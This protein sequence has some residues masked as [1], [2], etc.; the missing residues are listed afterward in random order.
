MTFANPE[1]FLFLLLL[2]VALRFK[3]AG[4]RFWRRGSKAGGAAPW[5]FANFIAASRAKSGIRAKLTWLPTMLFALGFAAVVVAGARPQTEDWE[6]LMAQGLDV[7][8]CLDMSSSMNAVDITDSE[9]NEMILRGEIPKN[10]FE[11]AR[12]ALREFIA[13]RKGDRVGLVIFSSDAYLKF[14]T[15]LD[16]QAALSQLDSLV[17]DNGA[18]GRRQQGCLNGCTIEGTKTAVGDALSRAYKRIEDSDAEGKIIILITDGNDNASKLKPLDVAKSIGKLEDAERPRLF[19]FLIGSGDH[20]KIPMMMENGKVA[21]R[22][23]FPQYADYPSVVDED[24]IKE[25][26]DAAGGMFQVSYDEGQFVEKFKDLTKTDW[27]EERLSFHK[28]EFL[29]FLLGGLASLFLG[30]FLQTTLLRRFP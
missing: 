28:E 6:E 16:Y 19:A 18:R 24:K 13:E 9:L 22:G 5:R 14:P 1:F 11:V 17:L 12:G 27:Q 23:G 7:M 8:I 3:S 20:S 10:R 29:P 21:T 26:V 25:L 15:T 30:F 4:L 2:P